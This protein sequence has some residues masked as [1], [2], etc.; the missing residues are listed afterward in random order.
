M[1]KKTVFFMVSLVFSLLISFYSGVSMRLRAYDNPMESCDANFWNSIYD[2]NE[3]KLVAEIPNSNIKFYYIKIDKDFGKYIG[4]ILQID[5]RK[6]YN[7]W[8]NVTNPAYAPKLMLSDL[9]RDGKEELIIKL[10]KG[11]GTGAYDEEIHIIRKESFN[12]ILVENP[13]IILHKNDITL[14]ECPEHFEVLLKNKKITLNKRGKLTSPYSK[15]GIGWG[16]DNEYYEVNNN[17]LFA[18][19]PLG[20]G[21]TSAGEFIIKYKFKDD[22]FQMESIDFLKL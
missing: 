14:K 20:I 21:A 12:E 3:R 13:S 6:K 4:L 10:C 9:D 22:I 1:N 2:V 17:T 15:V 7:G 11:Y 8:D 16:T 5:D 18:R 19:I